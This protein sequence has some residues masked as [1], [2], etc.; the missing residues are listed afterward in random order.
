MATVT[1]SLSRQIL[2]VALTV[3]LVASAT[4]LTASYQRTRTLT[5]DEVDTAQCPAQR[6]LIPPCLSFSRRRLFRSARFPRS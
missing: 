2:S 3:P 1:L 4:A 6:R 5:N